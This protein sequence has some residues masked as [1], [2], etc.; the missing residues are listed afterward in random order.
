ME[1][2]PSKSGPVLD[3]HVRKTQNSWV[4]L[5]WAPLD[6]V[7]CGIEYQYGC[8]EVQDGTIGDNH[9]LQLSISA[10]TGNKSVAQRVARAEAIRQNRA[11]FFGSRTT[12]FRS[13]RA[14]WDRM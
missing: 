9:H 1:S 12:G 10:G 7:A 5:V 8:R 4:N 11:Q 6:S 14:R 13:R 2:P 3:D